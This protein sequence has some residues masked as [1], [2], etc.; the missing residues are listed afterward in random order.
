M[1]IAV[2]AYLFRENCKVIRRYYP[3]LR[4]ALA[5]LALSLLYIFCNPY[6]YCR[7]FLQRKGE[8]DVYGYGETP[9]TTL[10]KIAI[11]SGVTPEDRWLELGAGRGRASF[12]ISSFIGCQTLG[13]EWIERFVKRANFIARIFRFKNLSFQCQDVRK[14]PF[15]EATIVYLYGTSWSDE[16]ME[17]LQAAMQ[18]LPPASKVISISFALPNFRE[19][20]SFPVSFPWGE[21]TAYLLTKNV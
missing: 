15:S 17:E 9:L 4:F 8:K 18:A 20:K 13:V 2:K 14:A 6:R 16:C 10:E 3:C 11:E 21:T 1:S 19:L 12:W 7:K 5:D